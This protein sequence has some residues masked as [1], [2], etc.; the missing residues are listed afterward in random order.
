MPLGIRECVTFL[1]LQ[2]RTYLG[3]YYVVF[4]KDGQLAG[5]LRDR[6]R[7]GS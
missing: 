4:P 2:C 3:E 7:Q 1:Q 6:G 5:L